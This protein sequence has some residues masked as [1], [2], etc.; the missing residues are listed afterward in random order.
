MG[1]VARGAVDG[2]SWRAEWAFTDRRGGTSVAP[3][4]ELNL[5]AS[6]GDDLAHVLANRSIA[7]G[8]VGATELALV[9]QVHGRDVVVL[10]AVPAEPP[11]ADAVVTAA[12]GL[13]LG[14]Q[15]ADCVPILLADV[16][17]GRIAAVHAG[18]RGV[19]ANVVGAALDALDSAPDDVQAW[20]GPA[21]CPACYEVSEDVRDEVSRSAPDA[22]SA[23]SRGTPAVDLRAGVVGQL[24]QRGIR[25]E[26]VGGCT[27]ESPDLFSYR[28]DGVTGRQMG[29]IVLRS[30]DEGSVSP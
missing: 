2:A 21:I 11:D 23:T 30:S 1:V 20:I 8:Y 25:G 18:W 14:T 17:R 24:R 6:V 29:I 13:A 28:R 19:A 5:G 22:A 4:D 9:R 26:V 27:Y 16:A 15:V 3:F 10:E 12:P 7:A